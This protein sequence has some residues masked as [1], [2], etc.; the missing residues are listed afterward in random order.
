MGLYDIQIYEAAIGMSNIMEMIAKH[1]LKDNTLIVRAKIYKSMLL[2]ECGFINESIQ[3]LYM[4][5]NAKGIDNG[6]TQV[7][8]TQY[9]QYE[10]GDNFS[11]KQLKYDNQL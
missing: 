3:N 10:R 11:N 1:Y 9:Y 4:I 5:T 8:T 6:W 2:S 7:Q